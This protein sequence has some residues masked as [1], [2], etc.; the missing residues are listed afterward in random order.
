[1]LSGLRFEVVPLDDVPRGDLQHSEGRGRGL[2]LVVHGEVVVADCMAT[3]LTRAGFAART[4]Y[5]GTSALEL[6]LTVT[7]DLLVSDVGIRGIDGIKLA[8]AIVNA[9]PK[10]KVLLFSSHETRAGMMSALEE[11]YDFPSLTKPVHPADVMK[12]VVACFSTA[13]LQ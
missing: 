12:R 10:C 2:V 1:M 6:A 11:G 9:M 5:D 13:P 8:M 3:L 7:P 4:A